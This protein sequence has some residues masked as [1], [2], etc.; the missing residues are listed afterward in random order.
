MSAG[1]YIKRVQKSHRGSK[2]T[3]AYLHLVENVRTENGPRQRLILNLGAV[4]VLPEQY[5]ELANCIEAML[6]G[7]QQLFS[8][9]RGIEKIARGAADKIRA[10]QSGEQTAEAPEPVYQSVDVASIEAGQV[11]SLGPEYVCHSIWR[12][13]QISEVLIGQGVSE[14]V[15]PLME[16]LVI[17][18]LVDPGSEVHTWDWAVHRSALYE[19]TG[20]PLRPSL[21][22]LYRAGDRL[23]E[24]KE[25]L[26]AHL[27]AREKDLFDLPERICLFD[28]TNTYFEG[29]AAANGKAQRGHSKEK[30]TDCKLLTLAL[31]VDELG[32]A[33]YSRL[34]PGNQVECRS[35]AEIMESLVALRPN[36]AK[37]RTVVIDAGIATEENVAWLKANGFHYIVVQRGKADFT[38]DD[39]DSMHVIRDTGR[40]KLEIKR[41]DLDGEALLLCRSSGR[42]QKDQGIRGRQERLFVERLQY[43]HDGLGKKGHT[44]LYP[45]V[46][47]MIGRLREKYPRASKLYD[48]QV[49]ADETPGAKVLAK[50]IV[51]TKRECYDSQRRFEGCY[52]LRTDRTELDDGQIWQTYVMLT[53]VES[54]FRSL[55]SSLGLRPNFHQNEQRADAHLFISVL[56]YHILHTIEYKLRQ[57]G[58]Q[59]SWATIGD[60]LST[61]QRLTVEYNVKEQEQV[62][63]SHLRLCSTPEPEHRLIYQRLNLNETP[64]PR[65]IANVK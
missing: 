7:Q 51:W 22:S 62:L 43:Y 5:K 9:D 65:K 53:R 35:L 54:A 39:T 58:D 38:V 24:C 21:N 28:L 29:Q 40:Y 4:K 15:L 12:E 32:F 30:R 6:T 27:A 3:Y 23:F 14:H 63:R 45:K 16:A 18:R 25:A 64:L 13:L 50:A 20:Q 19:L 46:V 55:K 44:K 2:K 26:E 31:V 49:L 33:K 34:Y 60:I 37:D 11:R 47:E 42:V 59:R 1:M 8:K 61:H 17:G 41:R 56:A 52:V 10:K 57:C 36:L 48:V